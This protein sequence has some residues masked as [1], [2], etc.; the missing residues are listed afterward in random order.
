[1]PTNFTHIGI[2]VWEILLESRRIQNRRYLCFGYNRPLPS[3]VMLTIDVR[4]DGM[5]RILILGPSWCSKENFYSLLCPFCPLLVTIVEQSRCFYKS[6]YQYESSILEMWNNKISNWMLALLLI[7]RRKRQCQKLFNKQCARLQV[8]QLLVPL[9]SKSQIVS[10][11]LRVYC[12]SNWWIL[13][14][15]SS[16]EPRCPTVWRE[17][18]VLIL[19]GYFYVFLPKRLH[20]IQ[21][22]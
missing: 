18:Q 5:G 4:G 19:L 15:L 17:V 13:V 14:V 11:L 6:L 9:H 8:I 3:R 2:V 20:G 1:M 7:L 16:S 10:N 12:F 22:W 21:P